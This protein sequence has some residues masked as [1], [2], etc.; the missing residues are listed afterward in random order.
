MESRLMIEDV[1]ASRVVILL[2]IGLWEPVDS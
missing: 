2:Q 1:C